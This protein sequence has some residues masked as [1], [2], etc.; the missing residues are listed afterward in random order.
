M[1]A[2]I[3][4]IFFWLYVLA[5]VAAVALVPIS[6]YEL[7]GVAKDPLSG[8][9]AILL[10]IPWSIALGFLFADFELPRAVFALIG[11]L[12]LVINAA[13]LWLLQRRLARRAKA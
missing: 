9:P 2:Q 7:F 1:A 8:I 12:P 5:A 4:R 6:F 3:V 13:L 10:G 11:I